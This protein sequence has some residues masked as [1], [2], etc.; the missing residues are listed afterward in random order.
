MLTS[1]IDSHVTLG[2]VTSPCLTHVTTWILYLLPRRLLL[3]LLSLVD[4][5]TAHHV[6]YCACR[7][8]LIVLRG[9]VLNTS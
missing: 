8:F 4:S 9:H 6:H 2:H 5:E 7:V 3:Y 1:A